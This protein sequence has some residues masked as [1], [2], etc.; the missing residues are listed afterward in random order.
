MKRGRHTTE[1]C[2][3]ADPTEST[4]SDL[5]GPVPSSPS[6]ASPALAAAAFT[7]LYSFLATQPPCLALNSVVMFMPQGFCIYFLASLLSRHLHGSPLHLLSPLRH[8]WPLRLKGHCPLLSQC[9]VVSPALCFPALSTHLTNC[10]SSS[11]FCS[12]R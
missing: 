12:L 1:S 11:A 4:Y 10:M 6:S 7:L 3:H 2:A 5:Q 9:S 8:L